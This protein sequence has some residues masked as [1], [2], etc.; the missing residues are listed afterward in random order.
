MQR[1][2]SPAKLEG[3]AIYEW[4]EDLPSNVGSFHL[5]HR[6]SRPGSL[7][8][9]LL[10]FWMAVKQL[11]IIRMEQTWCAAYFELA[12]CLAGPLPAETAGLR[13]P[14]PLAA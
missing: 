2:W 7:L 13:I 12:R 11:P 14:N 1:N 4:L 3:E 8:S 5:C 6:R 10:R 9:I